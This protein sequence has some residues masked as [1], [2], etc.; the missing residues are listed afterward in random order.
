MNC[1]K[2]RPLLTGR[3]RASLQPLGTAHIP[4]GSLYRF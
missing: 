4:L 2:V 1:E 3:T